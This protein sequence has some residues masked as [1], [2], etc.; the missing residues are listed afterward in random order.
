MSIE[1]GGIVKRDFEFVIEDSD[2]D[3]G[4]EAAKNGWKGVWVKDGGCSVSDAAL[5]KIIFTAKEE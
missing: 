5:N 2:D 3:S 1:D 4:N